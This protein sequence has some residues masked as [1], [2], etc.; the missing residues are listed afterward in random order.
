M[1]IAFDMTSNDMKQYTLALSDE[2]ILQY[3]KIGFN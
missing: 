3:S 2:S 1:R